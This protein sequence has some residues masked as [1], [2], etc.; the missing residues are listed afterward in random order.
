MFWAAHIWNFPPP[1]LGLGSQEGGRENGT[2]QHSLLGQEVRSRPGIASRKT[3]VEPGIPKPEGRQ[4]AETRS[5]GGAEVYF[6]SICQQEL[7]EL[8]PE[9]AGPTKSL[10]SRWLPAG[11]TEP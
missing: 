7:Q 5:V 3:Q 10:A 2:L 9:T 4:K 6:D 11:P 1:P 8:S